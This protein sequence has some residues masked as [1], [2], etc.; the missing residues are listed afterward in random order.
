MTIINN[1]INGHFPYGNPIGTAI[2]SGDN[3]L[4][5]YA[6]S[7]STYLNGLWDIAWNVVISYAFNA[8]NYSLTPNSDTIVYGYAFRK[9][10]LWMNGLKMNDGHYIGI[11]IWK[12]YNCKTWHTLNINDP[13]FISY[14]FAPVDVDRIV[15]LVNKYSLKASPDDIWLA[16]KGSI[17]YVTSD[18]NYQGN[19]VKLLPLLPI[20]TTLIS[21]HVSVLKTSW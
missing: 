5:N 12:D 8:D 7:L 17:D 10:W 18:I 13:N 16:A 9:H 19:I 14:S 4:S 3:S 2:G 11:I 15:T 1:H 6:E 20:N 21:I